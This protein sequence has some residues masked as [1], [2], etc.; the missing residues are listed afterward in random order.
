MTR[1]LRARFNVPMFLDLGDAVVI[2][3][4]HDDRVE[5]LHLFRINPRLSEHDDLVTWLEVP[6]RGA[7]EADFTR[8]ARTGGCIG[9]P[10]N[11]VGEV[12]DINILKCSDAAGLQQNLVDGNGTYII[13]IGLRHRGPVDFGHAHAYQ[14][15]PTIPNRMM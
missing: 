8:S 3:N 15:P 13:K 14:H 10:E 2:I 7:V 9:L 11:A 5:F 1:H 12:G 6:R 4:K